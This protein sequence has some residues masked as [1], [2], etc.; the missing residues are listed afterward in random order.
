MDRRKMCERGRRGELRGRACW[1]LFLVDNLRGELSLRLPSTHMTYG[2][3]RAL[4]DLVMP[5]FEPIVSNSKTKY[6][7]PPSFTSLEVVYV[8]ESGLPGFGVSITA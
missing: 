3:V 1:L 2:C 5:F 4:L 8:D 6:T 7:A